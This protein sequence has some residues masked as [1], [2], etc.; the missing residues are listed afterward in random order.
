L[1]ELQPTALAFEAQV[2]R[3]EDCATSRAM[4]IHKFLKSVKAVAIQ[5]VE[6][7]IE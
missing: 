1:A 3:G 4:T 7:L 5:G 6:W 2:G